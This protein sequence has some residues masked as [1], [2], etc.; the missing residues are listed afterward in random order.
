MLQTISRAWA[1]VT[2][3]LSAV[4]LSGEGPVRFAHPLYRANCRL[5]ATGYNLNV[6]G[7]L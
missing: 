7:G 2:L 5:F 1:A 4:T 6:L 3:G